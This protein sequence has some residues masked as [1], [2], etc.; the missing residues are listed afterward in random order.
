MSTRF[1]PPLEQL[2]KTYNVVLS[3]NKDQWSMALCKAI[4]LG[5]IEPTEETSEEIWPNPACQVLHMD[6]DL[7]T[8]E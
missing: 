5:R 7:H 6:D 8:K 1:H 2:F 4:N 3:L